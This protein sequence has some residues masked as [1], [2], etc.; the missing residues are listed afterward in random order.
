[1][2][3]PHGKSILAHEFELEVGRVFSVEQ[4]TSLCNA[5][6]W[7]IGQTSGLAQLSFTERVNV[8]DNSIDADWAVEVPVDDRYKT[9]II[10][11]GWNVFQYKKRD[12]TAQGRK[13]TITELAANLR[14]ALR[15]ILDEKHLQPKRYIL[16]T[17]VHLIKKDREYLKATIKKDCFTTKSV[18][19]LIFGAAEL[20]AFTNDLP[21]LRSAYFAT[22]DFSTW[23]AA[24]E[25]HNRQKLLGRNIELTGRNALLD[26]LKAA[27]D[28]SSIRVIFISGPHQIGKS[29]IAFEA[30]RHRQLETAVSLDPLSIGASDLYE[31][32]RNAREVVIIVE[33]VDSEK[34]EQLANSVLGQKEI[35]LVLT[36]P[37]S[38]PTLG[39]N[40]GLDRRL[41][42]LSLQGLSEED[43]AALLRLADARF[44]YGMESWVIQQA[45]GNPGILLLAAR[46]PDLRSRAG[47]FTDQIARAFEQKVRDGYEDKG[48]QA[49]RAISLLTHV[50]FRSQK[51]EE[52]KVVTE[53]TGAK[54]AEVLDSVNRLEAAGVIRVR[55]SFLEVVPPVFAN[56]EAIAAIRGR[57][58]D[59]S[60]LLV[61]LDSE[62]QIRLIR[63]LRA[64]KGD[65]ISVFW[66]Q[67]F[68]AGGPFS[69]FRL[70]LQDT[71][72]LHLIAAAVPERVADLLHNGLSGMSYEERLALEGSVRRDLMWTLEQLLFYRRT[73]EKALKCVALLAETENETIGNNATAVFCECFHPLHP[74]SPLP[75]ALRLGTLKEALSNGQSDAMN[76]LAV[77]AIDSAFHVHGAVMLRRSEGPVPL[78]SRPPMTW[79]EAR[80]YLSELGS[81]AVDAA[82]SSRAARSKKAR[83][84]LPRILSGLLIQTPPLKPSELCK[85]IVDRIL[86][87]KLDISINE[88]SEH[89]ILARERLGSYNEDSSWKGEAN[90]AA[91]LLDG[92][93]A[94][95]DAASF[96][97]R[98]RRW[99]GGW[100]SRK[101]ETDQNGNLVFESDKKIKE[102]AGETVADSRLLTDALLNWLVSEEAR[103]GWVFFFRLGEADKNGIFREAIESLA[104]DGKAASA[105]A[106]Y[107]S[108]LSTH[109]PDFVENRLDELLRGGAVDGK[110][111][112]Y[113]TPYRPGGRRSVDRVCHLLRSGAVNPLEAE[114]ALVG[115]GWL[116]TLS[117]DECYDL[118]STVAGTGLENA[119]AVIDFLAMWL[120]AGRPLEGK[121]ADLT[122]RCLEAMP[123]NVEAY[124]ADVVAAAL[125]TNDADRSFQLLQLTM[126]Q[127]LG[128]KGWQ[129]IDHFGYHSFWDALHTADRSRLLRLIFDLD[130]TGATCAFSLSWHLPNLV[131]WGDD[132]EILTDI[133]LKSE[134]LA[135]LVLECTSRA[136]LWPLAI[137]LLERFPASK[138]LKSNLISRAEHNQE[139]IEGPQSLHYEK[140]ALEVQQVIDQPETPA[141]VRSFLEEIRDNFREAARHEHRIEEDESV[142]W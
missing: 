74:Q 2:T 59:L 128:T 65:E 76:V 125:V 12:V 95:M 119:G 32:Q 118:L 51:A 52:V 89:L 41:K 77:Q 84:L 34:A 114:R 50:G 73:S 55:G 90:Q 126:N 20:A 23:S 26:S 120:H 87:G 16:F 25:S 116:K 4:F 127:P 108:G 86:K 102:L 136:G 28:D 111:I 107:F 8:A 131:N 123:A 53:F 18:K 141:S 110:A 24:W 49:V 61:T 105:F 129:P 62:G 22:N 91:K 1:M 3:L 93:I 47:D 85:E 27:V 96:D 88:I 21:H 19:V 30:T 17:N 133:A 140:C 97:L 31:L 112:L 40:F 60:K 139:V 100:Q 66:Q 13:R 56:Y 35:K 46:T 75:L 78:D 92:C 101:H 6:A 14:G 33:V 83:S 44:D 5:I 48:L 43:S 113:A 132:G 82:L 39:V 70:A 72:L 71:P 81:L 121:L 36:V 7:C 15:Q 45:G 98:L 9:P 103:Q 80:E 67:F 138:S 134:R 99:V 11:P 10:G 38:D 137:K 117:S 135:V 42:H 115:G 122:W 29:R 68:S 79:L 58:A 142:N 94:G 57:A 64:L 104:R 63:R 69:E 54:L 37:S 106:A 109:N 124:D 130:M